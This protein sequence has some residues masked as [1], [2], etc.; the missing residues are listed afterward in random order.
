MYTDKSYFIKKNE[1]GSWICYKKWGNKEISLAE[2]KVS[3]GGIMEVKGLKP[4]RKYLLKR[5]GAFNTRFSL[6]SKYN[7]ELIGLKPIFNVEKGK[8]EFLIQCNNEYADECSLFLV[9]LSAYC[10]LLYLEMLNGA[11]PAIINV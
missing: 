9:L 6:L 1:T 4:V 5:L 11:L 2:I 8:Q 3:L 10:S 7:D